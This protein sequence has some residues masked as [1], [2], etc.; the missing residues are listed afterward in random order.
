MSAVV[1]DTH[2]VLWYLLDSPR[3]SSAA[4]TA[5]DTAAQDGDPIY[6]ASIS[7]VEVIYLAEKGRLPSLALERLGDTLQD[8]SSS[9][10]TVPLDLAIAQTLRRVPRNIVPDMPDR[11]I[12]ATALQLGLP[13][14]TRDANIHKSTVRTIW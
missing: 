10:I 14:V 3:L 2:T 13:L 9:F 4:S 1:A 12:A 11:I 6:I 7:F 8:Q 5:L